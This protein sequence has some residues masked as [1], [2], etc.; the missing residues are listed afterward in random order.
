MISLIEDGAITVEYASRKAGMEQSEFIRVM[1]AFKA[2]EEAE[3]ET[4]DSDDV[5]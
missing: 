3:Q 2:E 4:D 1:E 5:D